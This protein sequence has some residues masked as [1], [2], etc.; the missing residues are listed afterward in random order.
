MSFDWAPIEEICTASHLDIHYLRE[1]T[2]E[3]VCG[4]LIAW[5]HE[6]RQAGGDADPIM[7]QIL[8]EVRS[9][10]AAPNN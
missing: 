7:E 9:E 3:N 2:E 4:L 10:D 6:H 8:I 1:Q 5:Y